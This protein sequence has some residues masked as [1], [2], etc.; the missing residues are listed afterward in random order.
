[1]QC[2][3]TLRFPFYVFK[4]E[5]TARLSG[6]L[7]SWSTIRVWFW[8]LLV[9]KYASWNVWGDL[10]CPFNS[11]RWQSSFFLIKNSTVFSV[12]SRI[13]KDNKSQYLN[14]FLFVI[15]RTSSC[16]LSKV[17][18]KYTYL[19]WNM[20]LFTYSNSL[21]NNGELALGSFPLSPPGVSE[22][23][24][25]LYA[26]FCLDMIWVAA[27]RLICWEPAHSMIW[28]YWEVMFLRDRVY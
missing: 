4:T 2:V 10:R 20:T 14:I 24:V 3:K 26:V 9:H 7:N 23:P 25:K 12:T 16:V 1:M 17:E 18:F 15:K 27:Q 19:E 11:R 5:E 8:I 13:L 22:R 21:G 28:P 6:V